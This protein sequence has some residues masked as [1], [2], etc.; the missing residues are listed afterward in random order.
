[1]PHTPGPSAASKTDMPIS[2]ITFDL[3]NTLWDVEPSLIR[4]EE[5]QKEW[6]LKHRPGVMENFDPNSL[7]EFKKAVWKKHTHLSHNMTKMRIQTIYELQIAAGIAP[8][9]ATTGAEEAFAVFLEQRHKVKLYAEVLPVL[10]QLAQRYTIGALTNG[11]A[12]IYKTEA[13][14][15]FDFAFLAEEIGASKPKPDMFLA[16]LQ[17][18]ASQAR[19]IIH[20]GDDPNHDVLGA[21][22]VGMYT[23]W[24]NP[25]GKTWPGGDKADRDITNIEQLPEAIERI[26]A[27][28]QQSG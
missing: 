13:G 11:N 19:Q 21:Q 24:M 6:L 18:T 1:M 23:V 9:E 14:Q 17:E 8:E 7:L 16:A 28:A 15:Y 4:A 12:D 22:E 27:S 2:V 20:V 10:E 26:A 25:R 5:V 3:D